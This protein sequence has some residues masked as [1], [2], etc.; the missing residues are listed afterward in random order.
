MPSKPS[1]DGRGPSYDDPFRVFG[2]KA[3]RFCKVINVQLK[4]VRSQGHDDSVPVHSG[5]AC[6]H[7]IYCSSSIMIIYRVA[8]KPLSQ[9]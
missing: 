1:G 2:S 5:P 8:M 9:L 4:S 3:W 6:S 7:S